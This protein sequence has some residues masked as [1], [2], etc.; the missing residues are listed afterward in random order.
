M[1]ISSETILKKNNLSV[2]ENRQQIL[3]L[4]LK[5]RGALAHSD[6]E[7]KTR[8][9]FDRVT[10]YRTL[11]SFVDKGILHLIP[12]TDNTVKYALCK[13]DCP[14]GQHQDNHVHFTCT[15]CHDTSCLE[16]V[17]IPAIKLPRGFIP[18]QSQMIVSGTCRKCDSDV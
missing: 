16:D 12:T 17:I 1:A 8:A 13:D 10:V 9:G 7:K 3:E 11:Q 15:I 14:L 6:I 18:S 5:A 4:F 2:T